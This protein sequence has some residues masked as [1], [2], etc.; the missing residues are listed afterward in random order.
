MP[1]VATCHNNILIE[2]LNDQ[3][4]III[5]NEENEGRTI[6]KNKG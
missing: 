3:I 4:K 2:T 1:I 6:T 5:H